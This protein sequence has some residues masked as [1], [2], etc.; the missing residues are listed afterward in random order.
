VLAVSACAAPQA[1]ADPAQPK[2]EAP[3]AVSTRPQSLEDLSGLSIAELANVSV[4]SVSK[5]AQPLSQAAAAI[6]VITHD[7]VIRS[8]AQT[9]PEMLR[10]APNLQVYQTSS[11]GWVVTARGL[12]GNSAAQSFS[13]KLLVLIDGRSVYTP[14]FSG[15]YW[16]MQQV[17]PDDVDRIE[18]ISGPGATLWGAN[19]VNGVINIIT[20][21]ASE[22][23]GALLDVSGGGFQKTATA[24]YGGSFGDDVHYRIYGANSWFGDTR[25]LA[26]QSANDH[27]SKPQAGFRLGWT[28]TGRDQVSFQGDIFKGQE[29]QPG[30]PNEDLSG[31][32]F[33]TRWDHSFHDGSALQAQ[34]FFDEISRGTRFNG[35]RFVQDTY[36]VE[37]QDSLAPIGRNQLVVGAGAR[38]VHYNIH[39]GQGALLFL[40]ASRTLR[41]GDVFAQDTVSL[42]PN[43]DLIVGLKLESDP[44]IGVSPLP[45][46]RLSWRP[47]SGVMLWTAVS[48]AIRSP[49][50]FDR[51]VVEKVSGVTFLKGSGD[52]RP[53]GLT[54]YEAGG[55]F[56]PMERLSI[57]VSTY[58]DVYDHL[59]SIEATP[60]SFIPL[61]WG[62]MIRGNVYGVEAWGDYD[63]AAWWRLSASV[64]ALHDELEFAPGASRLLHVDQ[65][66]EDPPL[67][68][69]LHSAISPRTDVTW[70]AYLRHVDATPDED[71]PAYT[72]LNTSI[73]WRVADH[74]RLS[75]SGFNL[76]HAQ[77]R[78]Y[79]GGTEIPRSVFA[80]ARTWF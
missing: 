52:F 12:N 49:T 41:L 23:Q 11:S 58:Y 67:Q 14:L 79:A 45:N 55:R 76:L 34:A 5:H 56:H 29:A 17:V 66:G 64:N 61:Y 25:T 22:T 19:A 40:P 47:T 7:D 65:E 60:G 4:T 54:A 70:D 13:N 68:A 16:D 26:G 9:L 71:V 3:E 2:A 1:F 37:V 33:T 10:L 20:K 38:S 18:V 48:R 72:E 30:A 43:L 31:G 73:A 27:W 78:E 44:Y 24:Q 57:S 74:L 15:V 35:E 62:N 36:D 42:R 75:I 32:N 8:G 53:E 21:R 51:D 28:P 6:Y 50:P 39:A 59:R 80:E 77:H 63:V 46:V 69:S